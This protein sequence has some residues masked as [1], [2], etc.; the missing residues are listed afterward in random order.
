VCETFDLTVEDANHYITEHGIV[1]ANTAVYLDEIIQFLLPQFNGIRGRIRSGDP[2]LRPK[3]RLRA[4]TNPDAP[5]EGRWVK[6]RYVDPAPLGRTMLSERVKMFDGSEEVQS[7]IFIP[8]RLSDNPDAE[9]RRDYEIT[10]RTMPHH[11]MQARLHGDWNVVEGAFF[12]HEWKPEFHVVKPFEIPESWAVFRSMDWGY[13]AACVVLYWAVN[14]DGDMVCFREVTFNHK[15]KEKDRKDAQ[16]V[17][18]ALKDIEKSMGY[19]DKRT[20]SSTL[21]GPADYQLWTRQGTTGPSMAESMFAE[22]VYWDKCVKDRAQAAAEFIRR[23]RDIPMKTNARP[24]ITFFD[25]CKFIRETIPTLKVSESDSETPAE[26]NNDHWYDAICYGVMSR[27]ASA[28]R[29]GDSRKR[30]E[31]DE[32]EDEIEIARRKKFSGGWAYGM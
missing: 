15:C 26:A 13:K 21:R 10:L 29:E 18:L 25:T 19:W 31:E 4:A 1:N 27:L 14:N 5:P 11:V 2:I 9:C 23:L 32:F 7:R 20:D 22:G 8:A 24:A 3:L 30:G 6:E 12:A 16:L 28:G 17:A